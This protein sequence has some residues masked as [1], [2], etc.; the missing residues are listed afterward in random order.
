MDFKSVSTHLHFIKK[1]S[2]LLAYLIKSSDVTFMVLYR[3]QMVGC[4]ALHKYGIFNLTCP[5]KQPDSKCLQQALT[6]HTV[7]VMNMKEFL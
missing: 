5:L 7:E 4:D 6:L 3:L 2:V 1:V